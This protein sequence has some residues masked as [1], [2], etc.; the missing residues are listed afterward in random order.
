MTDDKGRFQVDLPAGPYEVSVSDYE[1]ESRQLVPGSMQS[2]IHRHIN[3]VPKQ[4]A[5]CNLAVATHQDVSRVCKPTTQ[6]LVGYPIPDQQQNALRDQ[7][8]DARRFTVQNGLP[9]GPKNDLLVT[10]DGTIWIASENGLLKIF[11]GEISR[12]DIASELLG[13]ELRCFHFEEE[14]L[15]IGA[16]RGLAR[17]DP[18]TNKLTIP[19][20]LRGKFVHCIRPIHDGRVGIATDRG[21]FV[22]D[23][24][25]DCFECFGKES[26]LL[27]QTC[28]SLAADH[29]DE[30]TWL[31]TEM[32]LA[33]FDGERITET[34]SKTE[35]LPDARIWEI[36]VD[37]R[38]DVWFGANRSIFTWD[39]SHFATIRSWS[40]ETY[41]HSSSIR[42][43]SSG[44]VW[45][46][47]FLP[48]GGTGIAV[49]EH[50]AKNALIHE[51][52][53][54]VSNVTID[55]FGNVWLLTDSRIKQIDLDRFRITGTP[56]SIVFADPKRDRIWYS[57]VESEK[58][59][60]RCVLESDPKTVETNID[61][62]YE[63][64]A[65]ELSEEGQ[66][67]VG[68]KSNGV[69]L[70]DGASLVKL[71]CSFGLR[72]SARGRER[73]CARAHVFQFCRH[74]NGRIY[75]ATDIGVIVIEGDHV[76]DLFSSFT[77]SLPVSK[78]IHVDAFAD[79]QLVCGSYSGVLFID[80]MSGK[81]AGRLG[82]N[83]GLPNGFAPIVKTGLNG[84]LWIGT[85]EGLYQFR[86]DIKNGS[87]QNQNANPVAKVVPVADPKSLLKTSILDLK[88]MVVRNQSSF[89]G[90]LHRPAKTHLFVASSQGVTKFDPSDGVSQTF[91][92]SRDLDSDETLHSFAIGNNSVWIASERG[93][94]QCRQ[95]KSRPTLVCDAA[96][97]GLDLN[98][99]RCYVTTEQTSSSVKLNAQSPTTNHGQF[100]FRYR[101]KKADQQAKWL[102][103]TTS[104]I[105]IPKLS[106]GDYRLQVIAY[107]RDLQASKQVSLEYHVSLPLV[108]WFRRAVVWLTSVACVAF[109]TLYVVNTIRTNRLLEQRV[110]Q[111]TAEALAAHEDKRQLE[112]SLLHAQKLDSL[113]TMAAG[114][115]H[116]FNN[117]LCAISSNME[118]ASWHLDNQTDLVPKYLEASLAA[119]HQASELTQTLLSFAGKL[120]P[121]KET[122]QLQDVLKDSLRMIRGVLPA[123][124]Q[125]E[126][127]FASEP[128]WCDLDVTQLNQ[129]VVNLAMNSR[130][131][132]PHGGKLQVEAFR[133]PPISGKETTAAVLRIQDTGH[134][135]DQTTLSRIF[136][137]FFTTKARGKGT[138]LGMSMVH[139]ILAAHDSEIS[140]E[141]QVGVG[142]TIEIRLPTSPKAVR[143]TQ[144][145]TKT[146]MEQQLV[147]T[148]IVADDEPRVRKALVDVL[149][150]TG[151]LTIGVEDGKQLIESATTHRANL[152]LIAADI[153]MPHV[154]GI[155]AVKTIREAIPNVPA[156]IFSG[157][158]TIFGNLE[159]S[160]T[161]FLQKPFR[162]N[163]LL[164]HAKRL[165]RQSRP[166]VA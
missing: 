53:E 62:P 51:A 10:P 67:L 63:I 100:V 105:S 87:I 54:V 34:V 56:C 17:F 69:M 44:H 89:P 4:V 102:T 41:R 20:E 46:R 83:D 8:Y 82:I 94:I 29:L 13:E 144:E 101:F 126:S 1:Q 122:T 149:S 60:L 129:V 75:C 68:T 84:T 59:Y 65:L 35:G 27:D 119:T 114:I 139:S 124:V 166:A 22:Y 71:E 143:T 66:L 32:G 153:D 37:S 24:K 52:A 145:P 164:D 70:F 135:M 28:F 156:I 161:V 5:V 26:G 3:V 36:T 57:S 93:L 159:D 106:A 111:R 128:I 107:D 151:L 125:I 11:G 120:R 16:A 14:T 118:L 123:S 21:L 132:M 31:G 25:N 141:S 81:L 50:A 155:T 109:G 99:G 160:Q 162:L 2:T 79:G 103:A 78:I 76:V 98:D 95:R 113:G 18:K 39:G 91:F 42:E 154:D 7:A 137:P 92:Q 136:E 104:T 117:S 110:E 131:A 165:T 86:G 115:A 33:K 146:N 134:G 9:S 48:S 40:G 43:D 96:K 45:C 23:Q 148:V 121:K 72:P 90:S 158:A 157:Q 150:E 97:A 152:V 130:D 6:P 138:G 112:H 19:H 88:E 116:D 147:G 38:G 142:T 127:D 55:R 140:I 80:A 49:Y 30:F 163:Q 133:V 58:R 85:S 61:T 47:T 12:F 73:Q 74:S 15:W 77:T 64:T 108:M